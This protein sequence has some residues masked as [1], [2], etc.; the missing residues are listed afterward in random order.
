MAVLLVTLFLAA[1]VP[2]PGA[3]AQFATDD[4][5]ETVTSTATEISRQRENGDWFDLYDRMHP[6]ARNLLPRQALVNWAESGELSIP[7]DDPTI[8]E[9]TFGAWRWNVTGEIFMDAATV[10][11]TQSV[12]RNGSVIEE[13]G[14]W[15]FV[16]DG[17]R[18]RWFP[19][20]SADEMSTLTA[21]VGAETNAYL[22]TFRR[23]AHVRIDR[24][25]ENVFTESELDYE[26]MTDI[27]AITSQPFETG[28]GI[29]EEIELY[30]IYYCTLDATVYYDPDFQED[31]VDLTGPYGFTTIIAHEWG[32]HIQVLLGIDISLDPELDGGL[33]P[34]EIEL[35]AD[36]LAGIYAQDALA[37][38]DIDEEEIE[39]AIEITS[40]SGDTADTEFDEFDAHGTGDQRIESFSTGFDDGFIGCNL[41]L[42]D[43]AN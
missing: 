24:F 19:E 15:V 29:E 3:L 17:Q 23:A 9:V 16:D 41:D 35:Q 43:Y 25:W 8:G 13:S 20:L 21:T 28:C 40:L 14:E 30:A 34:I 38:G 10:Q 33:Y 12:E 26:A 2:A 32:H 22:P 42:D 36:C 11:Y 7:S 39:A 27:V 37:I 31:V 6:S 18:W 5:V 1:M 4:R